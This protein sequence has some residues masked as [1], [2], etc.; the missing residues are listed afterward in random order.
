[1]E[2]QGDTYDWN[3]GSKRTGRMDGKTKGWQ[4]SL[5]LSV[6]RWRVGCVRDYGRLTKC[7]YCDSP[8]ILPGQ[9]SGQFQPDLVIPFQLDE[10]D[11]KRGI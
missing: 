2:R 9:V 4:E 7:P 11:A 3:E 6:L 1:M 8:V 10:N 5:Y